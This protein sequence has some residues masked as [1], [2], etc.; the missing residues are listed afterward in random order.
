MLTNEYSHLPAPFSYLKPSHG[1]IKDLKERYLQALTAQKDSS[2][3][4]QLGDTF[5]PLIK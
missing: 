3:T 4:I 2:N 5:K 1:N